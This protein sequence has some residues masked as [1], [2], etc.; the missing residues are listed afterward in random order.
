MAKVLGLSFGRKMSNSEVMVKTALM[1]CEKAG[2][3][4]KF[5]DVDRMDIKPCT[6]CISCV[7]GMI[8]GRGVGN[9]VMKDDFHILDEALM[10]CDA[11]IVCSPTYESSPTGRFKSV[12]D[13]IGPSHDITFRKIRYEEGKAAGVPDEKLPDPRTWKKRVGAL[14]TVGGAMTE[15]WL[16]FSLPVMYEMTFP[17]GI[18]VID[19]YKYYGAMAYNH[20]LGNETV[21]ERMRQ[22]GQHINE[23][24]AAQEAGDEEQRTAW[25]GDQQGL[26]PVCHQ[27]LLS[28]TGDGMSVDCPVC[29]SHGKLYVE[30]GKIRVSFSKEEQERSRL[31][32]A[33]K[34]EHSTEIKTKAAGPGQIPNLAELKK[35]YQGFAEQEGYTHS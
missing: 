20:V 21:M 31:R 17:L 18:D 9:C 7:V 29:G 6:G 28:V 11:L 5:L 35:P 24:L 27:S 16:D 22:V 32:W 26:C 33:G 8:S 19:T 4:V 25:R 12:C 3:E 13:R 14:L 34:L 1:E 2:H 15:N 10:E 30:D 23:A